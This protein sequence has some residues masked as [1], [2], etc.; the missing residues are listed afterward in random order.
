MC[1]VAGFGKSYPA[2]GATRPE[3]RQRDW[4]TCFYTR[5]EHLSAGYAMVCGRNTFVN[6]FLGD[7]HGYVLEF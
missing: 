1:L 3:E 4:E 6:Q 2:T 7:I 5:E